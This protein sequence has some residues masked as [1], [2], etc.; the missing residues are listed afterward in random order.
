[1]RVTSGGNVGINTTPSNAA[2]LDVNANNKGIRIPNV[3]LVA[4]NNNA[5]I[6]AGIVNSL[7]V[8][9]TA[10]AG[11][12][13]NAVT[14]GYYYWNGTEWVRLIDNVTNDWTLLGN[15]GTDPNVNFIG[16][17]DNQDFVTRTNNTE[18]M[19]VTSGG[20]VGIN[21]TPSN[22]A[23][24]DVNANNRGIRIPNVH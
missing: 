22:A 14:P 18:K 4:R 10:T 16:T 19:R 23:I 3:A 20:N 9:N 8:Y 6:G 24:L 12:G 15:A 5:P 7:L 11:T 1:M 2:I 17:T 21:T 13:I